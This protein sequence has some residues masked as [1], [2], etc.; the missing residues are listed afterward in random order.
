MATTSAAAAAP[1]SAEEL[2]QYVVLRKDLWAELKWPLGS[3]VA[4]ACH[5]STAALWL[6]RD[7]ENT[8]TYTAPGNFDNMH[9]VHQKPLDFGCQKATSYHKLVPPCLHAHQLRC[10]LQV[11]LEIKGES[12][13]RQLAAKL[14]EAGVPHK[15]WIEQPED[16]PTCLATAPCVKEDVKQYFK[17]LN[18]CKGS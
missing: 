3:I 9:K 17:K 6:S 16:F 8:V 7:T 11:V 2:I 5:A 13:L 12:Q 14:A 4:Q 10:R 18:L 15:L 1:A